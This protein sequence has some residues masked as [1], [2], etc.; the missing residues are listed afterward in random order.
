MAQLEMG[1][2]LNILFSFVG[3]ILYVLKAP[4]IDS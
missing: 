1:Q 2:I 3:R 4:A